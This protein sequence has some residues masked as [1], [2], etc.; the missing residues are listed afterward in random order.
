[1]AEQRILVTGAAGQIGTELVVALRERY[2]ADRV[3]ASDLA[4]EAT[5]PGLRDGEYRP[6]DVTDADAIDRLVGDRG[7]GTVY[8]LAALLSAVAEDRHFQAWSVNVG[9]LV[10]VLEVARVRGTAVFTPSS[11]GA[12]GPTTPLD[13]TPQ[14]TIQRPTSIYGVSKVAGELLCDYYHSKFGVD[15]RGL[16]YPGII[17][18]VTLPGGGT[19]D[20]AVEIYYEA[21]RE[22][23]YVCPLAACTFLDMVYMPDAVQGAI[24]L[25]EADPERLHHRNAYNVTAMAVDPERIAGEI[26]KHVPGFVLEYDVDPVKQGIADSWPNGM[27]DSAARED[28]GW[29]PEFDLAAMTD[30]MLTALRDRKAAGGL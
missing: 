18:N 19:T 5:A 28:W 22:G 15:T 9:G 17:S 16:R 12:F 8:H 24:R 14:V 1:M 23:R 6:L 29:N 26:R 21:V 20:Y 10:N 2:G 4:E 27:D 7:V 13:D 25:M 30:D 11:I 3:I